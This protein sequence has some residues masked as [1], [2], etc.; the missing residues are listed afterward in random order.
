VITVALPVSRA[1][2]R[3]ITKSGTSNRL[4]YCEIFV[5]DVATKFR[6]TTGLNGPERGRSISA[7][8]LISA[9]GGGEWLRPRPGRFTP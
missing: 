4:N 8:S 5:V 3:E 2:R 1:T 7:L 6:P 9:L